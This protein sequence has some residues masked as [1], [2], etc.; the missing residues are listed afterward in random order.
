M[1]VF[2]L[3]RPRSGLFGPCGETHQKEVMDRGNEGKKSLGNANK[4]NRRCVA[5]A[6]E[7]GEA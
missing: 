4:L 1:A 7:T 3:E 5:C 2:N 6:V